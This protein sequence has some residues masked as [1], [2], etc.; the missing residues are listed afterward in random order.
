MN[1]VQ[2]HPQ[3]LTPAECAVELRVSAP[4]VYRFLTGGALHGVKVGGQWRIDRTDLKRFLQ[5]DTKSE[6]T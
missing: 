4:S 2:S 6:T 3:L 1:S 5:G